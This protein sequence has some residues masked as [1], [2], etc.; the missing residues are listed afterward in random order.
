METDS[1]FVQEISDYYGLPL[2][3]NER[4]GS[5]Y[6]PPD[7]KVGSSYFKSTDGHMGQWDFSLRRLNMQ[8]LD[9][10]KKYGG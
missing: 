4:C 9:I 1:I 3:A 5:W 7:K 8:V 10:L 6:I 2:V